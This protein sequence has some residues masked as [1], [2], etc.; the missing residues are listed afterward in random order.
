M[1]RINCRSALLLSMGEELCERR[2]MELTTEGFS[3]ILILGRQHMELED[4]TTEFP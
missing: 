2:W 1:V 3:G 4:L